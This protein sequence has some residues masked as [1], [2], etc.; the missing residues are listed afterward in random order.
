MKLDKKPRTIDLAAFAF[1]AGAHGTSLVEILREIAASHEQERAKLEEESV[2]REKPLE[3]IVQRLERLR[4]RVDAAWTELL[5]R[6]GHH[7]PPLFT[8]ILIAVLGVAALVIDAILLGPG[9]DAVGVSDP[10]M[11]WVAAFGLA[12]LSSLIFHL[13]LETFESNHLSLE[14]KIVRRGLAVLAFAALLGWGVLRG[15]QVRFGADINQN[16]LG[17][18]LGAHPMLAAIFFCFIT[19]AAPM[20]GALAIHHC[21]PRIYDWLIW[22]RARRAHEDLHSTL[23]D[24]QKKLETERATLNHQLRQLNAR[25]E[26]WHATAAQYHERGRTHGARQSPHW[27]VLLK[28]T[29]W[30]LGG[31]VLGCVAGPF[32][33]PLYFALPGGAWVASFLYYRHRRFH[34]TYNEFK[35]LENTRFAAGTD[36]P[37]VVPLE[38]PKLLPKPEDKK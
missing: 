30:S 27:L 2:R 8:A 18:F 21:A 17:Q 37:N 14:T 20:A 25:Q 22:N 32:L 36:R 33:A 11:Q 15:L 6:I 26:N 4:P 12:A 16:P 35:G 9:L 28:S 38:T 19:L 5:Q 24:A 13:A 7:A 3:A 34:P 31:L 1:R 10:A 29:A 23:C